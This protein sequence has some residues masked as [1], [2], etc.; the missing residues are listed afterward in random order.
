[1]SCSGFVFRRYSFQ[2]LAGIPT[3]LRLFVVFLSLSK[4]SRILSRIYHSNCLPNPFQFINSNL[5]RF[6]VV[7]LTA[8]KSRDSAVCIATGYGLYDRG[9]GVRVVVVAARIFTSPCHPDRLW[10]PPRLLSVG[11][12]G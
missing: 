3:I 5:R 8:S 7:L 10:G 6:I 12:R 11:Y 2:F 1:M 9:V 4:H